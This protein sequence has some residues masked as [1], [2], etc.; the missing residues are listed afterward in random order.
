MI[1]PGSVLLGLLQALLLLAVAPFFSGLSR[2]L[3]AKMHSRRGPGLLQNYRDLFKLMKRQEVVSA[4][5]TWVFRLAPYIIMA[6]LLL[7]AAIL[8]VVTLHSPFGWVG[9][10]LLVI[11]LY[12]LA[13]FFFTLSGLDT[14]SNFGG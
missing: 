7:I 2:V 12:A 1:S 13:R 9:D 8:P 14:G 6:A 10:L 5:T 4:Q 11:Y 3:R